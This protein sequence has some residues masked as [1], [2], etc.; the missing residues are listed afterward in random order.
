[1]NPT[2]LGLEAQDFL[3]RFLRYASSNTKTIWSIGASKVI[4]LFLGFAYCMQSM[5]SGF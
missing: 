5:D 1:M 2:I 4:A 3:I